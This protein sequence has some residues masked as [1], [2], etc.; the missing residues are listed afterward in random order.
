[1]SELIHPVRT[2][3]PLGCWLGT[4]YDALWCLAQAVTKRSPFPYQTV[5]RRTPFS[6]C[7][8]FR[9][10]PT[11]PCRCGFVSFRPVSSRRFTIPCPFPCSAYTVPH[12][13]RFA[14]H[15]ILLCA[16][17]KYP[18]LPPCP[19]PSGPI[20]SH[21]VWSQPSRAVPHRTS[22]LWPYHRYPFL[23]P[24]PVSSRPV[25]PVPDRPVTGAGMTGA[26]FGRPTPGHRR[27]LYRRIMGAELALSGCR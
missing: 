9:S 19:A 5:T 13:P 8:L 24:C 17:R 12:S 21:A 15:P 11:V 2:P 25:R 16:Q 18:F 10:M 26:P 20:L 27:S 4:G 23:L 3:A 7:S 6:R 1:M 22:R 14:L